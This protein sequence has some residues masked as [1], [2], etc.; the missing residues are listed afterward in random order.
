MVQ[1]DGNGKISQIR[2]YWDQATM[3]RQVE[4]IG[5]SGRNWPIR[6]GANQVEL[7]QQSLAAQA[8]QV[9]NYPSASRADET[10]SSRQQDDYTSRLFKTGHEDMTRRNDHGDSVPI[11]ESAR[12]QQ[13]NYNELFPDGT[14]RQSPQNMNAKIGAGQNFK[15][16]RLF[17]ADDYTVR[18]E[19][20]ERKPAD[21][22]RY[23]HFDM[24]QGDDRPSH[25]MRSTATAAANNQTSHWQLDP[26]QSAEKVA[27]RPNPEQ[28]RHFGYD[29]DEVN[30]ALGLQLTLL[31]LTATKDTL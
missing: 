6:E 7:V 5:K 14:S 20:P 3:L 17:N 15:P 26:P 27:R 13:R 4:A 9:P 29:I 28:E 2:I 31:T 22:R 16:N 30:T 1:L 10:Q 19:S 18:Q 21:P 23:E 12:P 24:S 11:R 25:S 8:S